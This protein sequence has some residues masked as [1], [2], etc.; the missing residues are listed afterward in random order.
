MNLEPTV[1]IVDDDEAIRTGL[2]IL[3]KSVRIKTE[4]FS[5]ALA[6]LESYDPLRP[7]C[8][9]MDVRMPDISGL[10]L[11]Q[12]LCA[13]D[14]TIPVI[15]MS[16]YASVAMSVKAMRMGAAT[17]LEKPM[18]EQ[19]LI[20]SV[21]EAFARDRRDRK[22]WLE[23]RSIKK[24]LGGLSIR[25]REV[26]NLVVLGKPNKRIALDLGITEKTVD[27]HRANIREKTGTDSTAELVR[28][29]VA[30]QPEAV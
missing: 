28:L 20:E 14:Y 10:E 8:L 17:F 6:F 16:G 15:I 22:R 12:K 23:H 19:A 29:A 4:A 1:F 24:R 2:E 26:L 9:I 7:R 5:C 3:L 25:E 27:F 21:Q 13:L 18:E 30:V 11:Q